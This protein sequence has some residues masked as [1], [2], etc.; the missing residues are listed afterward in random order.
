MVFTL[1][2]TALLFP[3]IV[4]TEEVV[5]LYTTRLING[6]K[7]SIKKIPAN[8][9]PRQGKYKGKNESLEETICAYSDIHAFY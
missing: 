7:V 6:T 5:G 9:N 8:G 4:T 3:C 1:C 2:K